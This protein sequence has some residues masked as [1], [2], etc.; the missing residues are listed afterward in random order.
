MVLKYDLEV[1]NDAV[2]KNIERLTNLIFK[3]LPLREEG[4]DWKTPLQNL[5]IEINGMSRMVIDHQ[6]ILFSVVC[7]LEGLMSLD[8]EDDFLLFRKTIFETLSALSK[9]KECLV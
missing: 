2:V 7:R 6:S 3:L 5:I 8:S 4:G 1:P 9:V